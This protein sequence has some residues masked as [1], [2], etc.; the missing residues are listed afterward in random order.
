MACYPEH[1]ARRWSDVDIDGAGP[2]VALRRE[3]EG[4]FRAG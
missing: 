2:T 4:V 3:M 1:N